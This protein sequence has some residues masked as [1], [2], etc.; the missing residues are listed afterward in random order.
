MASFDMETFLKKGAVVLKNEDDSC[1]NE[2]KSVISNE[3][4]VEN[5]SE[6]HKNIN[7][8][9]INERR[10]AAYQALNKNNY[11]PFRT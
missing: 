4:N 7:E 11:G 5:L 8:N 3:L 1:W 6:I 9:K 10:M 2:L